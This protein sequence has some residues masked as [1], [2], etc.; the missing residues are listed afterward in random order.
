MTSPLTTQMLNRECGH[1]RD[2][3][4]SRLP[5]PDRV[6]LDAESLGELRLRHLQFFSGGLDLCGGHSQ[7]LVIGKIKVVRDDGNLYLFV[8]DES[9]RG[10]VCAGRP[11][12]HRRTSIQKILSRCCQF[13]ASLSHVRLLSEFAGPNRCGDLSRAH[14]RIARYFVPQPPR[15]RAE[16]RFYFFESSASRCALSLALRF[17][18]IHFSRA[19]EIF[20]AV[21]PRFMLFCFRVASA[22]RFHDSNLHC[23]ESRVN[24][25]KQLK[26]DL[27]K[28]WPQHSV[29]LRERTNTI[30]QMLA[31][32]MANTERAQR[33]LG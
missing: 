4:R 16:Q 32:A 25:K 11:R 33:I 31:Q 22:Y 28:D 13:C 27:C 6:G 12:F 3:G 23:V 1:V 21:A 26:V 15:R 17:N 9:R 7:H 20:R 30:A 10:C 18:C 2:W 24:M 8:V 19:A 14:C 5:A 29:E